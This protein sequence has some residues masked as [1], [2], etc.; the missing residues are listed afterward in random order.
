MLTNEQEEIC[1]DL[2]KK[3]ITI[4]KIAKQLR[5]RTKNV[6][7]SLKK[8]GLRVSA[9]NC[10]RTNYKLNHSYFNEVNSDEKAYFLGFLYADGFVS[11]VSNVISLIIND[12]CILEKF[13]EA[14]ECDKPF[15]L[16]ASHKKAITFSISSQEMKNDLIKLGCVYK[17][18][19]ILEFPEENQVP[20]DFIWAFIRGYFDGDGS[21]YKNNNHGQICIKFISS[22]KF[23]EKLK[24]FLESEGIKC[25]KLMKDA[26]HKEQ[27]KYFRIT[28]KENIDILRRKMY[29]VNGLA[30]Q[31]KKERFNG[32]LYIS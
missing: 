8:S 15:Y 26:K 19:L 18:S 14:I 25:G 31:R 24:V 11:K 28:G 12:L 13:R 5:T 16:N 17:K 2:Y 6:S 9:K 29:T 21:I 3:G 30:L 20:K 1:K 7:E 22:D 32:N 23:C 4:R 27:T 10:Y